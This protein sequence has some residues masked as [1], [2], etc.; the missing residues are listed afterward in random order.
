M[1]DPS[2]A[3]REIEGALSAALAHKGVAG[4]V[5]VRGAVAELHTGGEVN[6]IELGDWAN[7][8]PLLPPEI[9]QRKV[10]AVLPRL[11]ATAQ[12][13]PGHSAP[14]RRAARAQWT[15]IIKAVAVLALL[16]FA[17]G[18]LRNAN[19]FGPVEHLLIGTS[20]SASANAV[21]APETED[22]HATRIQRTCEA[23]RGRLRAG[24]SM[25]GLDVEGW[26]AVLWL[27]KP[28]SDGNWGAAIERRLADGSLAAQ[29]RA[30][31]R[32]GSPAAIDLE[33][34]GDRPEL[35]IARPSVALHFGGEYV[36]A[37][38]DPAGRE[39]FVALAGR[40]AE[41]EG[42]EL[43]AL[44]GQCAH[45]RRHDA[46]AWYWGRSDP[47]AAV[48]LLFAAGLLSD[49]PV[50]T[51]QPMASVDDGLARLVTAAG[52]LGPRVLSDS[53]A[54]QGGSLGRAP[55]GPKGNGADGGVAS[56]TS[57]VFALGGPTRAAAASRELAG[58]LDWG[59]TRRP[60]G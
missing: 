23:A 39:Q 4:K 17:I 10:D 60:R 7:Q 47:E 22:G 42:A 11:L 3:E 30:A 5:V 2:S 55:A 34:P 6:A 24:G 49:P 26:E 15:S 51:L 9:Q 59:A 18:W 46:G 27:A 8:W 33:R 16:A 31:L 45:L 36:M 21:G 56:G 35:A 38:F 43:A 54:A 12:A 57:I 20:A 19:F 32:I 40:I 1:K 53:V 48:A 50:A 14:V 52:S 58:K 25:A 41:A 13:R 44:Y 28:G 29:A 37:F